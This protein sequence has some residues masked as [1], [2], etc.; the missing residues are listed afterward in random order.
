VIVGSP[1]VTTVGTT[2][3]THIVGAD[4]GP[5]RTGGTAENRG[6]WILA[7]STSY[8]LQYTSSAASNA[9]NLMFSFYVE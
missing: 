6:E 1:T 4:S 5:S 3:E 9:T 8:I 7:A 2:L